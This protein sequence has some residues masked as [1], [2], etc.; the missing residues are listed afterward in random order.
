M[1]SNNSSAF[2]TDKVVPNETINN[3]SL[4]F[5]GKEP[6]TKSFPEEIEN[7]FLKLKEIMGYN[8]P[9]TTSE[10]VRNYY[11]RYLKTF[12]GLTEEKKF[13]QMNFLW[14]KVRH[15]FLSNLSYNTSWI[16]T[17]SINLTDTFTT[18]MRSQLTKEQLDKL[19][20]H[21]IMFSSIY[22][23]ADKV[24][25]VA[26][27]NFDGK[28][29]EGKANEEILLPKQ[30]E[31]SLLRIFFLCEPQLVAKWTQELSNLRSVNPDRMHPDDRK[32]RDERIGVLSNNINA[33]PIVKR[34]LHTFIAEIIT[35]IDAELRQVELTNLKP[36]NIYDHMGSMIGKLIPG[37]ERWG[38]Q[39]TNALIQEVKK[40]DLFKPVIGEFENM[41]TRMSEGKS[42]DRNDI[43]KAFNTFRNMMSEVEKLAINPTAE[44]QANQSM[45]GAANLV[46]QL[47]NNNSPLG[48]LKATFDDL[49]KKIGVPNDPVNNNSNEPKEDTE[50]DEPKEDQ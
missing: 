48:Q 42:F 38:K 49:G 33:T 16:E 47:N 44:Q 32:K 15:W 45:E 22:K 5:I 11:E 39:G 3:E 36:T 37:A 6:T 35:S 4:D 50:S 41:T 1:E 10:I 2:S 27:K 13:N 46:E 31:I 12:N 29:K 18:E 21:R 19:S 40:V 24:R 43:G 14:A 26:Y 28:T 8:I 34:R 20:T 23:V 17:L 9:G 30:L 25:D 7:L